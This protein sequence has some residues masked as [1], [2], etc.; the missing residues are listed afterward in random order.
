MPVKVK[1]SQIKPL[2]SNAT[3]RAAKAMQSLQRSNFE[4]LDHVESVLR[5]ATSDV[6]DTKASLLEM[7]EETRILTA[8]PGIT[9][10]ELASRSDLSEDTLVA[11]EDAIVAFLETVFDLLGEHGLSVEAARRGALLAVASQAWENEL[12]PLLS[13]ADVR[14][15]LGGVS[16]QRVDELL[17]SKRL[18]GPSD[19]AGHRQYPAFQF[20]D[21]QPLESLITAFW[22]V[23]DAAISPWTAAAWCTAAD[24]AALDGLSPLVWARR[25]RDA[26]HL[27]R[28]ARQDAARLDQ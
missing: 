17:R 7:D 9:V 2:E 10:T 6:E 15:L 27:A 14:E 1:R 28:V 11:V 3:T 12:G 18:I 22:T 24:N 25:G 8:K 20:H 19:R 26:E 13:T 4:R 16:R 21:G 5:Q 23:A